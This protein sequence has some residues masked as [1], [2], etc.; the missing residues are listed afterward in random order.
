[1]SATPKRDGTAAVGVGVAACVACCAGP[2]LGF[3]GAIGLGT[4]AGVFLFGVAG[5]AVAAIG[6]VVLVLRRQRASVVR[7][8]DVRVP[9]DGPTIRASS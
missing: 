1:V 8:S 6:I 4:L 2:I 3:L 5:L 7:P 9:V